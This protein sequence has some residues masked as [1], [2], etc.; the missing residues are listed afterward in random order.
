MKRNTGG[1]PRVLD[2]KTKRMILAML[3]NG[4]PLTRVCDVIE[5]GRSTIRAEM[6][7]DPRFSAAVKSARS[8][9]E[10]SILAL[11]HKAAS[12]NWTAGAW[13]LERRYPKTYARATKT[14]DHGKVTLSFK[15][16]PPPTKS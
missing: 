14:L 10:N 9:F 12:K 6:G 4:L 11:I 16:A 13:L 15:Q 3:N 1:R 5:N 7:R 8:R 2:P